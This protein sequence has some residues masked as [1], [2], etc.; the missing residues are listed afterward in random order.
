[1]RKWLI[2]SGL[3]LVLFVSLGA[4]NLVLTEIKQITSLDDGVY[5]FPQLFPGGDKILFTSSNY[6]GLYY[7]DLETRDI[8][9]LSTD[10]GAG[11][12]PVF[13]ADGS[14][15]VYR[16]SE[17]KNRRKYSSLIEQKIGTGQK[18]FL[19]RD[20]RNLSTPRMNVSGE[21]ILLEDYI[22]QKIVL[23]NEQKDV[24]SPALQSDDPVVFIEN[25]DIALISGGEKR[26]FEPMGEGHYLWPSVSPDGEKLLFTKMGDATYVTDLDGKNP[27]SLGRANA[28]CWSPD[29]NWIVYMDDRDDGYVVLASDIYAVSVD[30]Q[31]RV[32]LTN[33]PD[34]I[35]MYPVWGDEIENMVFATDQGEIFLVRIETN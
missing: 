28:P 20:K 13:S 9:E 6:N 30:G 35:E 10:A 26:V 18:K 34:R 14:S 11:Y 16:I 3:I 15:V 29:G 25:T 8:I 32:Q 31:Q 23:S 5:Y 24:I 12:E 2:I 19:I 21:V 17:Y 33:T 22:P 4:Q 27:V 1:M 7:Y